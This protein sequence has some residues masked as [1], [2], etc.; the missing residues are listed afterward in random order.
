MKQWLRDSH[1]QAKLSC[2]N[3][4]APSQRGGFS[5]WFNGI[6][7]MQEIDDLLDAH[8]ARIR[9]EQNAKSKREETAAKSR[10]KTCSILAALALPT[11]KE[12]SQSLTNKGHLSEVR[13]RL[14]AMASNPGIDLVVDFVSNDELAL[15]PGSVTLSFS[16]VSIDK[17]AVTQTNRS[18]RVNDDWDLGDVS[19]RKVRQRAVQFVASIMSAT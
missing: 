10:E 19:E 5:Y 18:H 8:A 15:Q 13:E 3:A 4:K 2:Y 1:S 6:Q 11:L 17:L 16:Y 7:I 14:D 9:A 12:V